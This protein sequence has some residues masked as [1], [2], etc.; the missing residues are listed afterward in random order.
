MVRLVT[1]ALIKALKGEMRPS[2]KAAASMT[3]G[4]PGPRASWAQNAITGPTTRPPR[5]GIKIL[6]HQGA[7]RT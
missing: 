7:A 5:V 2:R 1:P 6:S 3:S 4:T